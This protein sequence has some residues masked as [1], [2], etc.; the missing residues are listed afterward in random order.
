MS[1]KRLGRCVIF[2]CKYKTHA[3]FEKLAGI[4]AYERQKGRVVR[5]VNYSSLTQ[6]IESYVDAWNPIGIITDSPRCRSRKCP[7]VF[8]DMEPSLLKRRDVCVQYDS[9]AAG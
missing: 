6:S 5:F 4:S 8:I 9:F 3:A 2:F 1:R 7:T